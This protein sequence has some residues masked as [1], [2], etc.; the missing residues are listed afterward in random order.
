[1]CHRVF[2][3]FDFDIEFSYTFSIKLI[4]KFFTH[5]KNHDID[6]DSV[7]NISKIL[8]LNP[9]NFFQECW[10]WFW[11]FFANFSNLDFGIEI[12]KGFQ[13]SWSWYWSKKT[14]LA[15]LWAIDMS[16]S[17]MSVAS[18][19]TSAVC[20]ENPCLAPVSVQSHLQCKQP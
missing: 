10:Y 1:M 12:F 18:V 15:H 9:S 6:I 14:I 16:C 19:L 5:F 4:L 8:I 2:K 7:P 13:D 20:W 17:D 11:L 3:N